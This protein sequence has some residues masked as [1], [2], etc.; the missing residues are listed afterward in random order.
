MR[1]IDREIVGG[2]IFSND[3]YILLGKSKPGGV[4]P[5]YMMVPGGGVDEN[6]TK[7]DAMK[8]EVLEEVGID[9]TGATIQMINGTQSGESEKI[10]R[11]T[12]ERVLVRMHF[13]DFSVTIPKPAA[14]I[15]IKSDDDFTDAVW[16]PIQNLAEL[17]LTEQTKFTLKKIGVL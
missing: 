4:Y 14:T 2:F 16:V 12:D 9:I 10:L 5:G 6:E 11:D 1:V 15:M 13:N 17:K 3:G 7:E 8:R